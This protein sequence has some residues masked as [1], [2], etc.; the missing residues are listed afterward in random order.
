MAIRATNWLGAATLVLTIQTAGPALAD[1]PVIITQA[2][3]LAGGVTPGDEPGFPVS[4]R[5]RGSYLLGSNLNVAPGKDGIVVFAQNVTIDLNGFSLWG[6]NKANHGIVTDER[7]TSRGLEVR[8]GVIAGFGG[9][10]V[11]APKSTIGVFQNLRVHWNVGP[12]LV[13]GPNARILNNTIELNMGGGVR[14]LYGCRVEGNTIV[15]N[16]DD[17]I[18]IGGGSVLGN[19]IEVNEG[20]GVNAPF[21]IVG[22]A[23]NSLWQN[24]NGGGQLFDVVEMGF[25]LC[26]PACNYSPPP[27]T[28]AAVARTRGRGISPPPAAPPREGRNR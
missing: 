26:E 14:C 7:R 6:R 4:I 28:D 13:I 10:G 17:G 20:Y 15:A 21:S 5:N 22:A 3:A 11:Y 27:T 23:N 24:N 9:A 2:T 8:N 25:N 1:G 12:G 18:W 16:Q 19:I